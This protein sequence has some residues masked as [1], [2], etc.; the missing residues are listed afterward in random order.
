M[1]TTAKSNHG[2]EHSASTL[3]HAPQPPEHDDRFA[4]RLLVEKG[5]LTEEQFQQAQEYSHANN[6]ELML[7]IVQLRLIPAEELESLT[8]KLISNISRPTPGSA[9]G[10]TGTST[11]MESV[12]PDRGKIHRDVRRD[13]QAIAQ[14]AEAPDLIVQIILRAIECRATDI[15][16]DPVGGAC[17]VRYRIDGQLHDVVE[18]NATLATAVVAR[19]KIA[20]NLKFAEKRHA[21]DGRMSLLQDNRT[22]DLRISTLPTVHGEKIVIR[23]HE[24]MNVTAALSQ[25]GLEPR[26]VEQLSTLLAKP[27]GAIFAG[28]PVGAGKTTTLYCCLDKLNRRNRNLMTIEDPVETRIDG[29]NQ[30][31]VDPKIDLSF[32]EGLRGILRQDPDVLMIGEIRDHETAR[33]GIRAALTGVYVLSTI[34]A[35]DTA[36]TIVS[37]QNYGVPGFLLSASLQGVIS[38]RLVRKICPYCRYEVEADLAAY[39]ALEIEPD[40]RPGLMLARGRGCPACFQTGFLG[41]TGIF[42]VMVIDEGGLRDLI[43]VQTAKDVYRQVAIETHMQSLKQSAINRILDG[44]TSLEEIY[45]VGMI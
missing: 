21:Q 34:H 31:Q 32:E 9:A 8:L 5:L 28:A 17:N 45:R 1:E 42:E 2:H 26:Q 11:L 10:A 38:Q 35:S 24:T 3:S 18:L 4:A 16:F 30:V 43:M 15:H 25:L 22:R 40:E 27:Y 39:A 33:I 36:S 23:V 44:T 29:I 12:V 37:L 6:C 14:S 7:A 41:R 19:I 13:L 20:A